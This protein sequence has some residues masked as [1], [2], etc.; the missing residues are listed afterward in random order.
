MAGTERGVKE[1]TATFSACFGAP[2]MPLH[3]TVYAEMLGEKIAEHDVA[4][5]LVNTGWTGGPYG[6]GERMN[7]HHTRA[8]LNA[9]LAGEL[10]DVEFVEHPVF[11]VAVPTSC[12]G[13][14]SEILDPRGTWTDKA[15]YDAKAA[16]LAQAFADNFAE[17]GEM[18]EGEVREAGPLAA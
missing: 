16:E 7:I 2:F 1:P 17:F 10:D 12:R 6:V 11:R 4:V 8:M 13:V 3:P 15:A 18:V 5:W 14:P 9:A